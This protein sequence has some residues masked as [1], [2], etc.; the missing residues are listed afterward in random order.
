MNINKSLPV[1]KLLATYCRIHCIWRYIW[2]QTVSNARR[3]VEV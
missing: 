2:R 3:R 1:C